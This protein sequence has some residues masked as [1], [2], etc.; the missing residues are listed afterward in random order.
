MRA[1]VSW[2][3]EYVDLDE[4]VTGREI[5]EALIRAGLEV[6]GVERSSDID[7]P[8][9]VGRV[10]SVVDEPQKNGKVI[11]WCRVDVGAEHNAGASEPDP[12]GRSRGIICGAHN[13]VAGDLVVVALPGTT[14]PGGFQIASRKT[15]GHISDGMICAEDEIGIGTDH[16]GIIVL[17]SDAGQPGDD[18]KTLLGLGDEVLDIAVTPDMGYCLSIRGLARE[19][20]QSFG[21]AFTDPVSLATPGSRADGYPVRL[22]TDACPLFVALTVTG[23]DPTRPSPSWLQ[24]RLRMAGMRSISLAVDISNYV[25]LETGQPN[26]CYDGEKLRGP[27]VVRNA[28]SGERITT[29]DEVVRT[30]AA[31]DVLITDDSGPIGIGGVMG[32]ATTEIDDRTTTVVIE[33]ASFDPVT[34]ARASRR[35]KLSSEASKRFERG[36]DQNAAYAAARRVADLLVELGGGTLEPNQTVA[37]AVVAPPSTTIAGALPATVLGTEIA[38]DRVVEVLTSSG[39]AVERIGDDLVCTPPTW[40]PDLRDPY[41]YVEEVGC[42]IGLET[43]DPVVPRAPGGRG[44]TVRQKARRALSTVLPTLG[45]VE[46]LTFPFASDDELD[47]L[48]VPETDERRLLVRLANPLADTSPYLRTTMLPGLFAA[49][50]RN[51]SRGQDDLAL[52]EVGA[53]FIGP[54]GVAPMPSVADRPSDTD[55]AAIASAI[56]NQPTRIAC[57]VTGSWRPA[58]WLGAAEPTGW[59]HAIA[60]A[61]AAARTVGLELT[62][63]AAEYAPFHPGRCAALAVGD[64]VVGHAGELHPTVCK[65][66]GLPPR[67]AAAE[68]SFD[69]LLALAPGA[70]DVAPVSAWPIAKEDVALIVEGDIPAAA[71]EATLREG[72]GDLLESIHLFDVYTGEQAGEGRKSL[73]YALRFRA[74]DRTLKDA[75]AAAARDAAIALAVERFGA[76][77]RIA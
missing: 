19:T 17:P 43:I 51:R 73:A 64:V 36:V 26:H 41:D 13:F 54:A 18:A 23:V 7:G 16:A 6:E 68:L 12:E 63:T 67:T 60:L 66:Y 53:V 44:L 10:L 69:S 15:Y 59:R 4:A 49:V 21:A 2:L 50:A 48:G 20:A 65:A 31:E 42:K 8:L 33:C 76:V 40:R 61:E 14:L 47:K 34:I 29:L 28:V 27:I 5:G 1:P 75:E 35:H 57:V 9:V 38:A 58:G 52:Y 72:A 55:L 56:P 77:P 46:V 3:K 70:G 71:V 32:G 25:M 24:N 22:V 37:G 30:C 45:F 62:R 11:R 39:V 74:P